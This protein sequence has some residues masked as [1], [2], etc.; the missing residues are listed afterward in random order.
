MPENARI[1]SGPG[2][3]YSIL[4]YAANDQKFVTQNMALSNN[5]VDDISDR[6]WYQINLPNSSGPAV[7][8]IASES[9]VGDKIIEE[10]SD[11]NTGIITDEAGGGILLRIEA[12]SESYLRVW[13]AQGY[14]NYDSVRV[15]N[16]QK[17]IVDQKAENEFGT[18]HRIHIPKF[19]FHDPKHTK[20]VAPPKDNVTGE[21][22]FAWVK[23]EA[24]KVNSSTD[25]ANENIN[26]MPYQITLNQNY[27]NP[28]N[29]STVISYQ[30]PAS[31][32]VQLEIFD[33]TGRKVADLVKGKKQAGTHEITFD[34]SS[35]S[36][37]IYVYRLQAEDFV[38]TKKLMLIK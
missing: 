9:N 7:G 10:I 38:E 27:P 32:E 8:W 33:M 23:G 20:A 6:L 30:L 11:A 5:L 1:R 25:V 13:A 16:N 12:E 21:I 29:P 17:F 19:Y 22:E 36:S 31:S 24:I 26:E 28:F 15:W 37:G 14:N 4:G 2:T 18:W 34:A 35:L 3:V